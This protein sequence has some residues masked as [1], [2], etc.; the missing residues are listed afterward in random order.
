MIL[1]YIKNGND[2]I[3]CT[4]FNASNPNV[5]LIFY[6]DSDIE[7][8]RDVIE[9][10]DDNNFL[11]RSVKCSDYSN[12]KVSEFGEQFILVLSNED[13]SEETID[14]DIVKSDKIFELS[15]MARNLIIEGFDLFIDGEIKHFSL[16]VYDQ[17]NI[18]T[19]C[20]YLSD[21][22]EVDSYLYH[23]DKEELRLYS[24]DMLF[25]IRDEMMKTILNNV[26]HYHELRY[27]VNQATTINE[28]NSINW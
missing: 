5:S 23:A 12:R 26:Q 6:I 8:L 24:R 1:L 3:N 16:D 15:N 21:N 17:Q 14:L 28:V 9:L 10:Y 22:E 19:I 18:T 11:M 4:D 13:S 20:Q 25:N 7:N 2:V 27:N